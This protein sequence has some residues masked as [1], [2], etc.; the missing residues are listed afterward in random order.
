MSISDALETTPALIPQPWPERQPLPPKLPEAPTLPLEMLPPSLSPWLQDAARQACLPLEVLAAPAI[1]AASALVG[2]SVYLKPL[3]Y[4]EWKVVPNLWGA[5]VGSPGSQKS[6]A[7]SEA[8]RFL[9]LFEAEAK[10]RFDEQRFEAEAEKEA[11]EVRIRQ[12]KTT[13]KGAEVNVTQLADLM[14]QKQNLENVQRLRYWVADS[15]VEKLGELLNTNPMGLLLMRDELATWLDSLEE[16]ENASSRGFFLQ[17]WN[18]SGGYPFDR[19]GRG[20]VDIEHVCLSVVGGIQPGPLQAVF[21]RMRKDPKRADGLLPRL[22]VLVWPDRLPNWQS[23]TSPPNQNAKAQAERVFRGL[24]EIRQSSTEPLELAFDKE[25]GVAFDEWNTDIRNRARNPKFGDETPFFASWV[26]K[27]PKLAASLAVLFH[28]LQA[29]EESKRLERVGIDSLNLALNWCDFLEEHAKKV[30]SFETNAEAHA[31]H[32][33]AERIKR[34]HVEHG[35]RV[36]DLARAGW[37]G[38]D[39]EQLEAALRTLG[40]LGWLRVDELETG[41]RPSSVVLLHPELRGDG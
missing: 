8:L 12:A 10:Q 31:V 9:R 6:D 11:L 21:N 29:V 27:L 41:G 34:G 3:E 14:R 13:K 37:S 23:P 26:A 36:R 30:Y 1:V 39:P 25:A 16:E 24:L 15:T 35:A 19:I 18:G 28:L 38:L 7:I 17:G 4:S 22:Q 40:Q 20:T 2:R 32:A 5:V 33:L